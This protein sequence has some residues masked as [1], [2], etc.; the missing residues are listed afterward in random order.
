MQQGLI[1]TIS[2][3]DPAQSITVNICGGDANDPI[4]KPPT[5]YSDHAHYIS[6]LPPLGVKRFAGQSQY[7]VNISP[8]FLHMADVHPLSAG[9]TEPIHVW[10]RAISAAIR[11]NGALASESLSFTVGSSHMGLFTPLCSA[12]PRRTLAVGERCETTVVAWWGYG[13]TFEATSETGKTLFSSAITAS[14]TGVMSCPFVFTPAMAAAKKICLWVNSTQ[15]RKFAGTFDVVPRRSARAVR[16]AWQNPYGGVDYHTFESAQSEQMLVEKSLAQTADGLQAYSCTTESLKALQSDAENA[17]TLRHLAQVLSAPRV[18][19][20]NA[21]G[22][23]TRVDVITRSTAIALDTPGRLSFV[24]RN[25]K[26]TLV[27]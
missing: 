15:G 9:V 10:G 16:L 11:V 3:V 14:V 21:D 22:S 1:F 17:L 20:C 25:A 26:N 27:L 4:V 7:N 8:Y 6:T 13:I 24:I 5:D 18:W 2:E 23:H 12:A 19:L